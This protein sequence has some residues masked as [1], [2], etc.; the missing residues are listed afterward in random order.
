MIGI[1]N[2]GPHSICNCSQK[3]YCDEAN[4]ASLTDISNPTKRTDIRAGECRQSSIENMS[5]VNNVESLLWC[6]FVSYD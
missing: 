3:R 1:K 5:L 2:L 6:F 4:T